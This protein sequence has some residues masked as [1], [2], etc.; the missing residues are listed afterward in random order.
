MK[1]GNYLVNGSKREK[2]RTKGQDT[3]NFPAVCNSPESF[4]RISLYL[5]SILKHGLTKSCNA[6]KMI[7]IQKSWKQIN[8]HITDKNSYGP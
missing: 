7:E 8:V 3:L 4:K 6:I 1:K 2:Y 5:W